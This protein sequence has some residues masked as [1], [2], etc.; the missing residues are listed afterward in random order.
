MSQLEHEHEVSLDFDQWADL[1]ARLL[2]LD[3]DA[4]EELLEAH[5]LDMDAWGRCDLH[6]GM[7][8]AT[9]LRAGRMQR[10]Q[11]YASRFVSEPARG[12]Q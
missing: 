12:L 1:S 10:A 5:G 4:R 9:D 3:H 7:I 11:A 6:Y 8:I 2:K